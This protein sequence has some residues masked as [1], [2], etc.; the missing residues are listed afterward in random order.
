[1]AVRTTAKGGRA[2]RQTATF[3]GN[4]MG[5]AIN[6][7]EQNINDLFGVDIFDNDEVTLAF[8]DPSS[9]TPARKDLFHFDGLVVQRLLASRALCK[10]L[11]FHG[12]S[13]VGKTDHVLQF[14]SRLNL[15]VQE[16]SCFPEMEVSDL[17]GAPTILADGTMGWLDGPLT[18]AARY[19]HVVLFDEDD[20][21]RPGM[22][23]FLH[24]VM[25]G[26]PLKLA[27][28][29]AEVVQP[30]KGFWM[31]FTGNTDAGGDQEGLFQGTQE[32]NQA[33][34]RRMA[35]VRMK[36][37][38]PEIEKS[39]LKRN[40]ETILDTQF[41]NLGEKLIDDMV[42]FAN[43]VRDRFADSGVRAP[44]STGTL[45]DWC[46]AS[47]MFDD[48]ATAFSFVHFDG[49]SLKDRE[50]LKELYETFMGGQGSLNPV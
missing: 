20:L 48:L 3:G 50:T 42:K 14:C 27:A 36:Y 7:V 32:H 28:N 33:T 11:R 19:G 45:I 2:F 13:G 10:P 29:N 9:F 47:A 49:Q 16:I 22:K 17:I 25:D 6:I 4:T 8:G 46:K 26:R 31:I 39:I 34:L 24:A 44:I 5:N 18:I 41:S 43:A 15:P 23:A 30:C 40:F 12:L 21:L 37:L 1:M 35:H 38:A